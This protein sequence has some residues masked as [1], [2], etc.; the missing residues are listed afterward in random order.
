MN[1]QQ[2]HGSILL[3]GLYY[4][5]LSHNSVSTNAKIGLHNVGSG[6][7]HYDV[8]ITPTCSCDLQCMLACQSSGIGKI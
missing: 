3:V 7:L 2:R 8:D 6:Q 1:A 5:F 4:H